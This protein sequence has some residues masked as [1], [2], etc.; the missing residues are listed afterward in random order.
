[1]LPSLNAKPSRRAPSPFSMPWTASCRVSRDKRV[2]VVGVVR[3]HL[4]FY[5]VVHR[6]PV[7]A[8]KVD[9]ATRERVAW[10]KR[11]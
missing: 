5:G 11:A 2:N 4:A 1:M 8:Q 3:S 9:R 7:A 10:I 6:L